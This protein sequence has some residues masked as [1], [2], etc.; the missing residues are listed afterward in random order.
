MLFP[1]APHISAEVWEVLGHAAEISRQKWPSYSEELTRE[2]Q[3]EIIIQIQ[4]SLEG[5]NPR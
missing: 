4:R 3:V 5:Q 1:I 2:E